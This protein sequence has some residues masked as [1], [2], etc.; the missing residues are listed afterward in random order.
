MK[1]KINIKLCGYFA[2]WTLK[3]YQKIIIKKVRNNLRKWKIN[4]RKTKKN[5]R[6]K[7]TTHYLRI[8][9]R[10]KTKKGYLRLRNFI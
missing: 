10:W 6:R 4:N 2:G 9:I 7:K 3:K 5:R 1:N 8:E